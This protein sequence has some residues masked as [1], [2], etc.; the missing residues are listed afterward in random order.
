MI[1]SWHQH[2]LP[3]GFADAFRGPRPALGDVTTASVNVPLDTIVAAGGDSKRQ[4]VGD[5]L[6]VDNY[7]GAMAG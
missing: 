3:D 1:T 5:V 2:L 7:S 6:G 4:R